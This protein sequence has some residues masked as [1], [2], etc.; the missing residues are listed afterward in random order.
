[1]SNI[2]PLTISIN[3]FFQNHFIPNP[4]NIIL[5]DTCS[6]LD[7]LRLPYRNGDI[8]SFHNIIQ[9]KALIDNNS[10]YSICSSLTIA[11]WNEHE[12]KVKIATQDSLLTTSILH[13]NSI[14]IINDIFTSAHMTTKLDDKG[15]V[16]ELER[17][18]D[19]ILS[20][21]QF[22]MTDEIANAALWRVANKFP[23]ASKKQEF[24]DCAIWET[25]LAIGSGVSGSGSGNKVVFFTVNAE[26]FI[27]KS[28]TPQV[29][30]GKIL[31]EATTI[32]VSLS[33]TYQDSYNN[34]I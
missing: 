3:D 5:W 2:N 8:N 14:D 27:D 28:R 10:I 25:A 16:N 29:W 30:H 1:M 22:V 34:L 33:L 9:I 12:A 13:K 19:D 26:D 11:E 31:S 7:L 18:A 17:I 21:T 20:R 15:L 32:G 6:L 23:P 24:K 4:K